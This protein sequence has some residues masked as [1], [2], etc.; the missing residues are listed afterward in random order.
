MR[1]ALPKN[2]RLLPDEPQGACV[3]LGKSASCLTV[4]TLEAFQ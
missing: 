3:P 2:S 4:S 1:S